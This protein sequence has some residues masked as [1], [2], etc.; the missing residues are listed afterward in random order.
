M[1]ELSFIL[2][3]C[4][5]VY[6]I[7]CTQPESTEWALYSQQRTLMKLLNDYSDG[8]KKWP[9]ETRAARPELSAISHC[10]Q[11]I[12]EVK[13]FDDWCDSCDVHVSDSRCACAQIGKRKADD[14]AK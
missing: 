4:E 8:V 10:S 6:A 3:L 5:V 9:A 7:G 2:H 13:E 11:M 14:L 1:G 12:D